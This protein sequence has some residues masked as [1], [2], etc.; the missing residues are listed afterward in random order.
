M[1]WGLAGDKSLPQP[2]IID[3]TDA[4]GELPARLWTYFPTYLCHIELAQAACIKESSLS[5]TTACEVTLKN[6]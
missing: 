4:F 1:F 2:T 5:I 6:G 3:F